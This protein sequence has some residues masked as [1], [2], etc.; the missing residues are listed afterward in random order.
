[1]LKWFCGLLTLVL[2]S[3]AG[4]RPTLEVKA[5]RLRDA[6]TV[7]GDSN[8]VVRAAKL[9]KFYG[10][11]TMEERESRLG[12]YF[13]VSWNGPAG[14]ESEPVKVVFEY[15][16]ASTGAKI[17]KSVQERPGTE[18]GTVEFSVTADAYQKGGRVLAWRI[19]LYRGGQLVDT[20]R[21]YLWN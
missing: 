15:R 2:V 18:R 10:A 21:S 1:M 14:Q 13:T 17:L 9:Q 3:C 19:R 7:V 6:D 12:D 11:V 20:K 5:L 8:E 4:P 16:Q